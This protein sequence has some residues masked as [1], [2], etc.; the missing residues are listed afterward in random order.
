[1]TTNVAKSGYVCALVSARLIWLNMSRPRLVN[2][3]RLILSQHA[4][5]YGFPFAFLHPLGLDPH[6]HRLGLPL[7]SGC[8][9]PCRG[10]SGP[11]SRRTTP[12]RTAC[13]GRRGACLDMCAVW[14]SRSATD[15]GVRAARDRRA[16]AREAR[17]LFRGMLLELFELR[18]GRASNV[19][20]AQLRKKD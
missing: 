9:A 18:Y 2:P 12:C 7:P 14:A 20:C 17:R 6:L 13:R 8:R 3:G 4:R 5:F 11:V 1:M 10:S 15:R 19:L 16:A